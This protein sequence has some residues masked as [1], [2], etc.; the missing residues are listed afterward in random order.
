MK[1]WLVILMSSLIIL[2]MI[3]L[4]YFYTIP[5]GQVE[6]R[7]TSFVNNKISVGEVQAIKISSVPLES[8]KLTSLPPTYKMENYVI[9]PLIL[10][11]NHVEDYILTKS[12]TFHLAD[13]W[14]STGTQSVHVKMLRTNDY[15]MEYVNIIVAVIDSDFT[16]SQGPSFLES[17]NSHVNSW[18]SKQVKMFWSGNIC[19]NQDKNWIE[20][21]YT[22]IETIMNCPQW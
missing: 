13:D 14:N 12:Y 3:V 6:N 7:S 2:F 18:D 16:L 15:T 21:E 19:R 22:T 9:N 11:S 1:K 20:R 4:A 17:T 10:E 8:A 5:K